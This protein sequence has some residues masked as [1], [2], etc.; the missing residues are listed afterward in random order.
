[1][2][3]HQCPTT[4]SRA[5][6]RRLKISRAFVFD[7]ASAFQCCH[8]ERIEESLL[9]FCQH[10]EGFLDSL[11]M[12]HS[13]VSMKN[14][15]SKPRNRRNL[16]SGKDGANPKN[17]G[18]ESREFCSGR[19]HRLVPLSNVTPYDYGGNQC[20][21]NHRHLHAKDRVG[22]IVTAICRKHEKSG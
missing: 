18:N 1:M 12:T 16:N 19:N 4:C 3:E 9:H 14:K 21:K 22:I 10:K 8:S 13:K 17:N 20:E 6:C 2:T 11:G 5:T 15:L 7:L